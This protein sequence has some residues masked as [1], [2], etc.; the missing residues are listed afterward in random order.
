MADILTMAKRNMLAVMR[1]PEALFFSTLQPIMFVL[2]F[3]YVFGG[4][5]HVPG[6]HYIDYLM[7]GIFVQ[8]VIFGA[9]ARR[10]GWPRTCRRASSSA[11]APCP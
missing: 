1:T 10:P 5:I 3:T 6:G 11:S 2:L 8:T 9:M 7:P 4:A